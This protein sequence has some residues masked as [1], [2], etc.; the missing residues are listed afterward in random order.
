MK[1]L[2]FSE[3]VFENLGIPWENFWKFGH[4]VREFS[5]KMGIFRW[6]QNI[7]ENWGNPWGWFCFKNGGHSVRGQFQKGV[8]RWQQNGQN[9]KGVIRW[10]AVWNRGSM[11]PH[12]PVTFFRECPPPGTLTPLWLN[13]CLP[14]GNKARWI[15]TAISSRRQIAAIS[16]QRVR[17]FGKRLRLATQR[18]A[19]KKCMMA[20]PVY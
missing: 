4:S 7:S 14:C 3:S 9:K 13:P 17:V 6:E 15:L 16:R 10:E 1:L 5:Q 2:A 20:L 11:C 18:L 19:R 8:I 12:I